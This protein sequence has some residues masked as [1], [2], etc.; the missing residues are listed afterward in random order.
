MRFDPD[1]VVHAIAFYA[2]YSKYLVY[3][4]GR[5]ERRF[6]RGLFHKYTWNNSVQRCVAS[7]VCC[8]YLLTI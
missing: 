3:V 5:K 6:M 8:K 2:Q 7:E 4:A 1:T